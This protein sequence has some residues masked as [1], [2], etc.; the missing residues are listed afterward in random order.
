MPQVTRLQP[1]H[2]LIRPWRGEQGKSL[3][4]F[5]ADV[6]TRRGLSVRLERSRSAMPIWVS[7]SKL[8]SWY[9]EQMPNQLDEVYMCSLTVMMEQFPSAAPVLS[10][11]AIA[12]LSWR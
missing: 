4:A 2:R 5:T 12:I 9:G 10:S 6:R 8:A 3:R 7:K 1:A 11:C